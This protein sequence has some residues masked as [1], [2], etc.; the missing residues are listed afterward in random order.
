[1]HPVG[2]CTIQRGASDAPGW[3][4]YYSAGSFGCYGWQVFSAVSTD[5]RTWTKEPGIRLSNG[6][7]PPPAPRN[8]PPWPAGEGMVTEQLPSGDWRMIVSTY[9]H[10]LPVENKF[11]VTEWRSSNQID[12]TY[13]RTALSTRDLPSAGQRSVYSPTIREFAPGLWRMIVT[14][15]DLNVPGGRSRLWS[16]V[17]TDKTSWQ[18][19]GE[20][21][22]TAGV[23]YFYSTLVDDRLVTVRGNDLRT[24]RLTTTTI[25]M[26]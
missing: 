16:V 17:S 26:P 2:A 10:L 15:D 4:M 6:G 5:E 8:T 25:Q 7:N 13:V 20:L 9:E 14:A 22:S 21:L 12:W 18:L 19:E 3:R 11:Q 24:R 1:M 23:N